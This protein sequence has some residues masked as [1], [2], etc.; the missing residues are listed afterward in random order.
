MFK[1]SK[2]LF[3]IILFF[4]SCDPLRVL[5]LKTAHNGNASVSIYAN[6]KLLGKGAEDE[7]IIIHIPTDSIYEKKILFGIGR[8]DGY[9]ISN[10]TKEIDS[11][12]IYENSEKI[13]LRNKSE[14][15]KYLM[16]HRSKLSKTILT[17]KA[18]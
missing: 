18:G 17:I 10:L 11:I 8:W 1:L 12:I 3:F 14:I 7:K 9:T 2:Y 16:K 5:V 15:K 6:K 4:T 13:L